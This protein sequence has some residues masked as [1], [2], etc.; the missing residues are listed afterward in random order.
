MIR[1][2]QRMGLAAALVL[3]TCSVGVADDVELGQVRELDS[4]TRAVEV[5][6]SYTT[7]HG[8]EVVLLIRPKPLSLARALTITPMFQRVGPGADIVDFT[9]RLADDQVAPVMIARVMVG[10]AVASGGRQ[11]PF[12]TEEF[13][14]DWQLSA[15]GIAGG[16]PAGTGRSPVAAIGAAEI[17][18]DAVDDDVG[19]AQVVRIRHLLSWLNESGKTL[20]EAMR[21]RRLQRLMMLRAAVSQEEAATADLA[22]TENAANYEPPTAGAE[23]V[24]EVAEQ[25]V[26]HEAPQE[27][28]PRIPELQVTSIEA[29]RR[30]CYVFNF[31]YRINDAVGIL[32]LTFDVEFKGSANQWITQQP[33]LHQYP[34][35]DCYGNG[36]ITV[37]IDSPDAPLS[38]GEAN[39]R[40][41]ARGKA[42]KTQALVTIVPRFSWYKSYDMITYQNLLDYCAGPDAVGRERVGVNSGPYSLA[43]YFH[44]RYDEE[45]PMLIFKTAGDVYCRGLFMPH[46]GAQGLEGV[47]VIDLTCFDADKDP[48]TAGWLDGHL[49]ADP[50]DWFVS[51]RSYDNAGL[52]TPGVPFDLDR[53]GVNCSEVEA[54]IVVQRDASGKCFLNTMNGCE[55]YY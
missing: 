14:V 3:A 6:Y 54:D 42:G 46:E 4:R 28:P 41:R 21:D 25:Q 9:I 11:R 38:L 53:S 7:D 22:V 17:D 20:A 18:A 45:P 52:L 55:M 23:G 34:E 36:F 51:R 19:P 31:S 15:R 39:V 29:H 1:D 35:R 44:D 2:T 48:W 43:E 16:P 12:Y 30:G 24:I 32:P 13:D 27:G 5:A 10:L 50:D 49:P 8:D 37:W 26:E 40:L 33:F 47:W